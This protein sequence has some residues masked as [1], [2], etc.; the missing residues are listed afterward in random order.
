M[1]EDYENAIRVREDLTP[2]LLNK[3]L[4]KALEYNTIAS[5]RV[6]AVRVSSLSKPFVESI[7]AISLLRRSRR[8]L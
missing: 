5:K 6:I 7:I 2:Q 3:T 4:L 8:L 1:I